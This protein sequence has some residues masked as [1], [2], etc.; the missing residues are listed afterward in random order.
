MFNP[1]AKWIRH[2]QQLGKTLPVL[3]LL[4]LPIIIIVSGLQGG[5]KKLL[6]YTKYSI[7]GPGSIV[8]LFSI[9]IVRCI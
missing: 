1:H 2:P 9:Y 5:Q 4:T 7:F 3:L 6:F 8:E